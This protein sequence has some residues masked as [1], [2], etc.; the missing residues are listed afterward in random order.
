MVHRELFLCK[1]LLFPPGVCSRPKA[2]K[3]NVYFSKSVSMCIYGFCVY[4]IISTFLLM[5]LH[6]IFYKSARVI[7]INLHQMVPCLLVTFIA[8][9]LITS[10]L[11]FA[12]KG[13][14]KRVPGGGHSGREN[15]LFVLAVDDVEVL[16][17]KAG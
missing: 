16:L 17:D 10:L 9:W 2:L 15:I 8:S 14:G 1:C 3:D 4:G 13:R 11:S 5:F 12:K 7:E 6:Q